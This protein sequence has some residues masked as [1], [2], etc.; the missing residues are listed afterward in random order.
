MKT[1][2]HLMQ[3]IH[4]LSLNKKRNYYKN[5]QND[6]NKSNESTDKLETTTNSIHSFVDDSTEDGVT[7]TDRLSSYNSNV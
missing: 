7:L 4:L 6:R 3:L 5:Q 1:T 2:T